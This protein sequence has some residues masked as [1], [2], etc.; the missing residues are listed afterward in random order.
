MTEHNHSA[1]FIPATSSGVFCRVSINIVFPKSLASGQ[2]CNSILRLFNLSRCGVQL[3]IPTRT[4]DSLSRG[5]S[6]KRVHAS[7]K[8]IT[9][10]RSMG[11]RFGGVWQVHRFNQRSC[12]ASTSK[13]TAPGCSENASASG[14]RHSPSPGR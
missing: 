8:A 13:P 9:S 4:G 10:A 14:S 7:I 2:N 3:L 5:A 1:A 6:T 12:P 11:M